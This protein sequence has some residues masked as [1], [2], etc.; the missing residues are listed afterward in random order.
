MFHVARVE[1]SAPGDTTVLLAGVP[2]EEVDRSPG[3]PT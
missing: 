2:F 1:A 3:S